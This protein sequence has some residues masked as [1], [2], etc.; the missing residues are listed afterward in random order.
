MH[1]PEGNNKDGRWEEN[2]EV[3][4]FCFNIAGS[5]HFAHVNVKVHDKNY[6]NPCQ[7]T[8]RL[9][10]QCQNVWNFWI[11]IMHTSL[12]SLHTILGTPSSQMCSETMVFFDLPHYIVPLICLFIKHF[13]LIIC[14]RAAGISSKGDKPNFLSS[15]NSNK[16]SNSTHIVGNAVKVLPS[17]GC[18]WST[19]A[20]FGNCLCTI[21]VETA[22][23]LLHVAMVSNYSVYG[24]QTK[25]HRLPSK[26]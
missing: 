21:H 12:Y 19:N 11:C 17:H 13:G 24:A 4:P 6:F 5:V 9:A 14:S 16:K 8:Q 18:L 7:R 15:T 22:L 23:I 20:C 25:P 26:F 1:L 3:S 2:L 10:K